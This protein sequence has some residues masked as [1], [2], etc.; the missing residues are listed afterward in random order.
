MIFTKIRKV[1]FKN[2]RYDAISH[3][4]VVIIAP[5]KQSL[6][7]KVANVRINRIIHWQSEL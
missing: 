2:G 3:A 1:Y 4:A 5:F 6:N 7:E